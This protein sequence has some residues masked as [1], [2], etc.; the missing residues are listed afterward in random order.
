MN[1][2]QGREKDFLKIFDQVKDKITS[3]SGCEK[4]E[5]LHDVNNPQT[6]F[7]YSIWD[8]EKSLEKYRFSELFKSTWA[9]TKI[10]FAG[11]A[12]AWSVEKV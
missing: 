4:L 8:S 2:Q 12:E 5:L 7:T 10:L 3:F 11:K 9:K 1:F 6:F